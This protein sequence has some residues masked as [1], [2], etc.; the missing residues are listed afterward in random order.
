MANRN[1]IAS[2]SV[3]LDVA[4]VIGALSDNESALTLCDSLKDSLDERGVARGDISEEKYEG[5]MLD[6]IRQ[7]DFFRLGNASVPE[8]LMKCIADTC[9]L[10]RR[11]E[12]EA[13]RNND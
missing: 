7:Y 1:S 6:I 10:F 3:A 8:E 2:T 5:A 9:V 4:S 13:R 12:R 11:W